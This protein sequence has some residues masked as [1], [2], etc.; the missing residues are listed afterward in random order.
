MPPHPSE[1]IPI[2]RSTIPTPLGFDLYIVFPWESLFVCARG[3]GNQLCSP[4]EGTA[5]LTD[6]FKGN[7]AEG[8]VKVGQEKYKTWKNCLCLC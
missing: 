1:G 4:G 7:M 5:L 2:F 6:P 3:A 8:V